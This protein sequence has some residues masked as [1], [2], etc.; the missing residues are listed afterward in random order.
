MHFPGR[1]IGRDG[2]I[3]WPMRSPDIMQLDFFLWRHVKDILYMTPETSLDET[4]LR[5]V[6][7]IENITPQMP[8]NT[9]REI[10]YRLNILRTKK[11]TY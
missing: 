1:W 10:E 6:A 9:W 2:P 8:E 3:A 4:K 5:I 11:G 7:A